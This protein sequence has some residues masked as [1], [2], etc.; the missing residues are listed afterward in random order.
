M[1]LLNMPI[2]PENKALSVCFICILCVYVMC[3]GFFLHRELWGG[4]LH[5]ILWPPLVATNSGQKVSARITEQRPLE[6]LVHLQKILIFLYNFTWYFFTQNHHFYSISTYLH[7]LISIN[8]VRHHLC[9][10]EWKRRA[11]SF[12]VSTHKV[13][14]MW[15]SRWLQRLPSW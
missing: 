10:S 4:R 9:M 15:R 12:N 2:V 11:V 14:C 1:L 3:T 6:L 13:K 7:V 5:Q 8:S